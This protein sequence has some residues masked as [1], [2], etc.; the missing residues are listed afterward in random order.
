M[1]TARP[2]AVLF[3]SSGKDAA[4]ALAEVRRLGS[5]EVAAL[6]TTVNAGPP[7]R[8]AM[9]GVRGDLV[10]RQAAALGLPLVK[11][12]LPSPCPNQ[13]YEREVARALEP[14]RAAGIGVALFGDLF[15]ED[16]RAYRERQM[17][18]L[19]L[20]PRFPLWGRDTARLAREM[21]AAG[22][23]ARV[24]TVDSE[25]L[26][27]RFA[28]R[29][30][31]AALLAELPAGCDPCGENGEMHTFVTRAPGFREEVAVEIG[32]IA[33]GERFVRADLLPRSG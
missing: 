10:E 30:F 6:I 18:A 16:V 1:S 33:S 5:P 32:A 26:D 9:H 24:V 13:V 31:D 19:G 22:L 25:Q 15:L 20:E 2:H 28:G 7:E 11:V 21:L 4:F 14:L 3:W 8:V 17:A 23:E 29:R 27:A 12:P